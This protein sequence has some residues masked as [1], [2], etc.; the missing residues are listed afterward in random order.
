MKYNKLVFAGI[1]V[2]ILSISH[3]SFADASKKVASAC[4]TQLAAVKSARTDFQTCAKAFR[5]T[6][7][8]SG[9][10]GTSCSDKNTAIETAIVAVAT[11]AKAQGATTA[12]DAT[13]S[14]ATAE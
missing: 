10:A 7:R 14:T 3:S 2:A 11:C 4:L 9:A 6:V 13:V 5:S 12:T 1:V 8:S